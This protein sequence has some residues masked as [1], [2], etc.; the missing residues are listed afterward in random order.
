[1]AKSRIYLD[2]N[3]TTPLSD[4]A[5]TAL[6]QSFEHF[7]NASSVHNEGRTAKALIQSARRHIAESL[8]ANIDNIVF[9]S[10]A[11]ESAALALTPQY[12]MG[13]SPVLFSKL[14]IGAT[15]HPCVL[16]GGR[17][18]KA[19]IITIPVDENGLIHC[20]ILENEL[21]NHD[22]SA[23]LPLV[24]IQ[25]ANH[26]TGVLQPIGQIADI[27]KQA[28]G[29]F[30]ADIVQAYGKMPLDLTAL[31]ADFVF[32]S[33]HKLGAPK[34]IGALI[35]MGRVLMPKALLTGG[36]QE[37]GHRS[38]TQ[39]VG[40]ISAFGAAVED[41]KRHD[42]EN[43]RLKILRDHLERGLKEI[44]P[45]CI[46]HGKAT[47]R[48]PNT[49]FFSIPQMKAETLQIAYDLAGIAVSAG[50]ACSSGKVSSSPILKA[51]NYHNDNGAIRVS[52]GW[53]TELHDIDTFLAETQKIV[54]RSKKITQ[55]P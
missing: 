49:S 30:I 3:A 20:N 17:F 52:T 8:N 41:I 55:K 36:G 26:E 32:I 50:S 53:T 34:G 35:A 13:R 28:G 16:A 45:D 5:K 22:K 44:S 6:M 51:M 47:E 31:G 48:L 24:S 21:A 19:D 37:H 7:G 25:Y 2:F 39:A 27:V 46:I 54:S 29:V 15:E 11:T 43:N 14:Y 33:G 23:G 9:T 10:G 12:M 42:N 1:M 40:M 38:G 4:S 18:D